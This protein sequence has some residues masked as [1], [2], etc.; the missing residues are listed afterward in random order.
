MKTPSKQN[1]EADWRLPEPGLYSPE[2]LSAA[3]AEVLAADKFLLAESRRAIHRM[4]IKDYE[5]A[6][7]IAQ[8]IA[9]LAALKAPGNGVHPQVAIRSWI[10]LKLRSCIFADQRPALP[11][12]PD[13]A[14]N[15]PAD[16]APLSPMLRWLFARLDSPVAVGKCMDAIRLYLQGLNCPEI[17][18]AMGCSLKTAE[19]RYAGG[20]KMIYRMASADFPEKYPPKPVDLKRAT[21]ERLA[22]RKA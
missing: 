9:L 13:V 8:G 5:R 3:W 4:W 12:E 22:R 11:L 14:A 21:R 19:E 15:P 17:A 7:E 10:G 16:E 6:Y 1:R 20:K 18:A 2:A